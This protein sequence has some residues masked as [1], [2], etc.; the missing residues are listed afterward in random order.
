MMGDSD[1]QRI[2]VNFKFDLVGFRF[3]PFNPTNQN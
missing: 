2:T 3:S 1:R